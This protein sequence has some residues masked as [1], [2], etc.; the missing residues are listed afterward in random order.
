MI[1]VIFL[2][3]FSVLVAV[4]ELG[5][6]WMA[7][8]AGMEVQEFGFGIPPRLFGRKWKGT[9][10][11]INALPIGGFVRV[12]GADTVKVD[13]EQKKDP[14]NYH[15]KSW[16]QKFRFIMAGVFMN[17]VL[18][19]LLLAIGYSFGMQPVWGTSMF[20]KNIH[21][22]GLLVSEIL[23]ESTA[24]E[25]LQKDDLILKVNGEVVS[26]SEFFKKTLSENVN[27]SVSL[28]ISRS[29]TAQE[30]QVPVNAEGKLGI[31]FGLSQR[32]DTV[33]LPVWKAV[34][35]G[36]YQVG[37]I[38]LATFKALGDM[39]LKQSIEGVAGP[40]GLVKITG[41]VAKQG[42]IPLLQFMAILSISLGVL[43]MLPFPA[44]DGGRAL[45]LIIEGII[46]RPIS[47]KFE[48]VVHAIGFAL[49]LL[50]MIV[51]TIGDIQKL[52]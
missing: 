32:L 29:G 37:E 40:V 31:A 7:K 44:L 36:I 10:W 25:S 28:E 12:N 22:D 43:N 2:I 50:L 19:A 35:V 48:M 33:K 3:I 49:L 6:F 47:P 24:K 11:S 27:Q 17:F 51:V 18:A 4:H 52:F 39:I 21:T 14:L 5:H 41:E 42:V 34:G 15:S 20:E 38:S 45:F 9:L 46:R 23:P 26:D 13:A 16:W 30:V 8:K 1:I